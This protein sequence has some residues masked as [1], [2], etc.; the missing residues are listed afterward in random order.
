MREGEGLRGGEGSEEV[1]RREVGEGEVGGRRT[2]WQRLGALSGGSSEKTSGLS[3]CSHHSRVLG[4]EARQALP[5]SRLARCS[6]LENTLAAALP[7]TLLTHAH[8]LPFSRYT[9]MHLVCVT[10]CPC[11]KGF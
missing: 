5:L 8:Q 11:N 10:A 1:G 9:F 3:L 4:D 6:Q 2:I 7:P